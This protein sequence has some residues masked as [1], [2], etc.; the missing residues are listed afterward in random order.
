VGAIGGSYAG[1]CGRSAPR[2][3]PNGPAPT[4]L[5]GLGRTT[6]GGALDFAA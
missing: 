1:V 5:G 3:Y 4:G 6:A 2:R